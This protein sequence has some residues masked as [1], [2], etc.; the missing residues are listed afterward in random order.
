ME[1]RAMELTSQVKGGNPV[2]RTGY[3]LEVL[4]TVLGR[5]EWTLGM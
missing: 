2:E 5:N 1:Q 3:W 4:R